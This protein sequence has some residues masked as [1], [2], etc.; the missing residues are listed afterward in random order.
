MGFIERLHATGAAGAWSVD[1]AT[2]TSCRQMDLSALI[3]AALPWERLQRK[4]GFTR[5]DRVQAVLIASFWRPRCDVIETTTFRGGLDRAGGVTAWRIGFA[6][7]QRAAETGQGGGTRSSAL[8]ITP[9]IG[10]AQI[11]SHHEAAHPGAHRLR[12]AMKAS[13]PGAGRRN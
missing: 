8:P 9:R 4:S 1:G 12:M 7:N 5:P 13:F 6:I 2:G 10:R 11:G 3:S